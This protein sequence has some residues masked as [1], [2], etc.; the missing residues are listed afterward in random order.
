MR[1]ESLGLTLYSVRLTSSGLAQLIG[2]QQKLALA[3]Y[4]ASYI[5]LVELNI[6]H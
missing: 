2:Q 4:L 6:M 3:N 5:E 1:V